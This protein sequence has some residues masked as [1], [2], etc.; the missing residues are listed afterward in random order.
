MWFFGFVLLT[1]FADWENFEYIDILVQ[2][3]SFLYLSINVVPAKVTLIFVC[4]HYFVCIMS[5]VKPQSYYVIITEIIV[6][7]YV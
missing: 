6:T 3:L 4:H 1:D 2:F 5:I 7:V